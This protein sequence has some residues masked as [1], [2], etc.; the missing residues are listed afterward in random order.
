VQKG[1][2][3]TGKP[4]VT[5]GNYQEVRI[6]HIHRTL[7]RYVREGLAR[8]GTTPSPDVEALFVPES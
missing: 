8:T 6:R 7:D 3:S 4:G 2:H 1:L 5:L